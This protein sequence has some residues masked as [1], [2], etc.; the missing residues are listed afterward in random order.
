ML[1]LSC[2]K[3]HRKKIHTRVE[4]L[5]LHGYDVTRKW[6]LCY[7][8]RYLGRNAGRSKLLYWTN[9]LFARF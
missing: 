8:Y 2:R 9:D 3:T 6:Q 7:V 4:P 5:L 1:R